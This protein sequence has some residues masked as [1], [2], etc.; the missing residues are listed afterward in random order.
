MCHR[1]GTRGAAVGCYRRLFLADLTGDGESLVMGTAKPKP[2]GNGRS[3]EC[4]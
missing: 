4:A 2:A 3:Q 1:E